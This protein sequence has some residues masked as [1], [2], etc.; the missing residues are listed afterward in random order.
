MDIGISLYVVHL[1]CSY[2]LSH[3][4]LIFFFISLAVHIQIEIYKSHNKALLFRFDLMFE[5]LR[6]YQ[7]EKAMGISLHANSLDYSFFV[8][9]TALRFCSY[10]YL[11][12]SKLRCIKVIIKFTSLGLI[13][14]PES[15]VIRQALL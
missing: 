2:S 5:T 6:S 13:V 12:I 1:D 8:S 9:V 7:D 10:L 14:M 4:Y 15:K 3:Q 11:Y